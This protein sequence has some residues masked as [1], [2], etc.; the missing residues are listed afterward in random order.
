ML[1][2]LVIFIISSSNWK[3]DDYLQDRRTVPT[4]TYSR[5]FYSTNNE[6]E[7]PLHIHVLPRFSIFYLFYLNADNCH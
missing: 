6:S 3:K 2:L 7:E 4:F 1:H 5:R